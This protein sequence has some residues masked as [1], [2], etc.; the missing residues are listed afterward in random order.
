MRDVA[1]DDVIEEADAHP[2]N[3]VSI[4]HLQRTTDEVGVL[5]EGEA[6]HEA[7]AEEVAHGQYDAAG[8]GGVGGGPDQVRAAH[9]AAGGPHGRDGD[10]SQVKG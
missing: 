8:P 7:V 2:V 10:S 9:D 6:E 4:P 5:V 1:R 3:P